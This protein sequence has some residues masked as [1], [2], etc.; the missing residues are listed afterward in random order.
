MQNSKENGH[1]NLNWLMG[2]N[3]LYTEASPYDAASMILNIGD[4]NDKS[5]MYGDDSGSSTLRIKKKLEGDPATNV[6]AR[7]PTNWPYT[8]AHDGVDFNVGDTV[9]GT[10]THTNQQMA[11]GT[12]WID[13]ASNSR[14]TDTDSIECCHP[15]ESGKFT[16]ATYDSLVQLTA[17]LCSKFNLTENYVIRH[18]DI[19]GKDCPKAASDYIIL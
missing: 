18:Y 7:C 14:N 9:P 16:D 17:F 10:A 4:L 12:V 13:Y 1:W 11:F 6:A 5:T 19:T 2:V 8:Q 15:N 3:K